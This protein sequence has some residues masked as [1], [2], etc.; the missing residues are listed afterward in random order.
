ME[1]KT[2]LRSIQATKAIL[3]SLGDHS[4]LCPSIC[5]NCIN[6][7]CHTPSGLI[8]FYVAAVNIPPNL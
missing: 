6:V 8:L 5:A 2:V 3:F 7:S 4:K 1:G